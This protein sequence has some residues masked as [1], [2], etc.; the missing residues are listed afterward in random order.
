MGM[1]KPKAG[2]MGYAAMPATL[3]PEETKSAINSSI[4]SL[5]R[6]SR[7]RLPDRQLRDHFVYYSRQAVEGQEAIFVDDMDV[8]KSFMWPVA[9]EN[10]SGG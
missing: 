3:S 7:P 2:I 4:I 5:A 9:P 1:A 6:T 10:Y 8:M